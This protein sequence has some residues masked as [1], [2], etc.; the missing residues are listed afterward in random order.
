[1]IV[2]RI[3]A[4]HAL[5]QGLLG[6]GQLSKAGGIEGPSPPESDLKR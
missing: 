3:A 5:A 6:H 4:Q 1:M 2:Y